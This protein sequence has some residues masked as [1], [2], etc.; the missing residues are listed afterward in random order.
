MAVTN[1]VEALRLCS[2][3][4]S[5]IAV[6]K[7]R[8]RSNGRAIEAGDLIAHEASI[9]VMAHSQ[10]RPH[11]VHGHPDRARSAGGKPYYAITGWMIDL[12]LHVVAYGT[13]IPAAQHLAA[14]PDVS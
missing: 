2:D 3:P 11:A 6:Q 12:L 7:Q 13:P 8:C 9:T 10:P 5:L 1:V 14:E 4:E